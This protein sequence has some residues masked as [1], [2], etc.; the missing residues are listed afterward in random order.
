[1]CSS[2][3][4]MDCVC[5]AARH[6]MNVYGELSYGKRKQPR[7]LLITIVFCIYPRVGYSLAILELPFQKKKK[8]KSFTSPERGIERTRTHIHTQTVTMVFPCR[9]CYS[10]GN[11]S[12]SGPILVC[13][14]D[15]A[16]IR[17]ADTEDH[18]QTRIART[19]ASTYR[20]D[21]AK[22][23]TIARASYRPLFI[24]FFC[25]IAVRKQKEEK[26]KNSV[27]IFFLFEEI[28]CG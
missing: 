24:Y 1:M 21:R 22:I 20:V 8:K 5:L 14:L 12:R 18:C 27:A 2:I 6:R 17:L 11:E 15:L 28:R 4:S 23:T 10:S 13:K 3:Y 26:R 9:S 25:S 7:V 19:M 16:F